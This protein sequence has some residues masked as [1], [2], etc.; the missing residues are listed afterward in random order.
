MNAAIKKNRSI[1]GKR[2]SFKDFRKDEISNRLSNF[3]N[4]NLEVLEDRIE[5]KYREIDQKR[6]QSKIKAFLIVVLLPICIGA[7]G[8]FAY[9][10][11][12]DHQKEV[13]ATKPFKEKIYINSAGVSLKEVYY[14]NGP[15]ASKTELK[16][17]IR[18]GKSE[19]FYPSGELFRQAEYEEDKLITEHYYFKSGDLINDF[20]RITDLRTYNLEFTHNNLKMYLKFYDG[21]IIDLTFH[22]LD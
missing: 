16:S 2:K 5:Q 21:K 15:I 10:G 7:V 19:S 22:E 9:H 1:L 3:D 17:G 18:H 8:W 4:S 13:V 6:R 11:T 12:I 20:P 14:R